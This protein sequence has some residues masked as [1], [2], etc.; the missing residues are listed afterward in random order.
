MKKLIHLLKSVIWI[1][2][3]FI[4]MNF[5][6]AQSKS[7]LTG[8]QMYK[9]AK[10]QELTDKKNQKHSSV[11]N[12][13]K[14]ME[15]EFQ[16]TRDPKTN[17]IPKNILEKEIAFSNKIE[18]GNHSKKSLTKSSKSANS[19]DYH[20]WKNRGPHNVGGRTRA[21]ALDMTNENV[22]FAGGVSGG[23]WRS[24]N[25]G[26]SWRKVTNK[27]QTPS[28][29]S[30][31]QDPR[32][33]YQHIWYY[34]TGEAYGTA[35]EDGAFY[36]G[37]GIFKS[38]NGGRNWR[39]LSST[40]DN[41]VSQTSSFDIINSMVIHPLNGYL[42]VGAYDGVYRSKDQGRSFELVLPGGANNQIEIAISPSGQLYASIDDD[43]VP[44]KGF[45]TSATGDP[46]SWKNITPAFLLEAD[47]FSRTV[48]AVDPSNENKVYF[49]SYKRFDINNEYLLRYNANASTPEEAWTDL[50]ANLPIAIGGRVGNLNLQ[51]SYN[52]MIKVS[53]VDSNLI[54]IGGTNLYRSTTGFTTPAG[55]ESWI[56]GYSL[57]NDATVYPDHHP[58]L[59]NLVFYPSNPNK[60][61]SASDGGVALTEDITTT[62]SDK[63]PVNWISLNNGYLTTQPWHV[64]FDPSGNSDDLLAGFQDNGTWYTSS[65]IPTDPWIS[66]FSG[67]GTYSAIADNGKVRYVSAQ[68]GVIF[69]TNIDKN[70]ELESYAR[71]DP[72]V[73]GIFVTPYILDH[74]NDNIMYFCSR[75]TIWRNNNLDKIPTGSVSSPTTNWVELTNSAVPDG[76]ISALDVSTYPIAN[77][78]Y[79]GTNRG[80][81]FRMDNAIADNQNIV[82]ISTGKGFPE[83]AFVNDINIDPSNH[84]RVIVTFSNYNINSLFLTENGGETWTNISGNLEENADGSGNG[85]SVRSTAFFGGSQGF[86]GSVYQ[87]V[88]AATSTGLFYAYGLRGENTRW[89]KEQFAIGNAVTDEVITRKDG[90]IAL[91][92]HGNGLFSAKFPVYNEVPEPMLRVAYQLDDITIGAYDSKALRKIN[93]KDLF[94]HAKNK[95][96][97]I[98]VTNTNTELVTASIEKDSLLIAINDKEGFGQATIN[99]IA[100][101]GKEQVAEALT[102]NV[103]D[104]L[105]PENKEFIGFGITSINNTRTKISQENADD[106]IIPEGETWNIKRIF[107]RGF[108]FSPQTKTTTSVIIYANNDGKPGEEIY[109]SG[110]LDKESSNTVDTR[111]VVLPETLTLASGTYW[112]SVYD[113]TDTTNNISSLF[114]NWYW[115]LGKNNF[116]YESHTRG[117]DF[118]NDETQITDWISHKDSSDGVIQDPTDLLFEIYGT[119]DG[120]EKEKI[121]LLKSTINEIQVFPNPSAN[122]FTFSFK[123]IS[124]NEKFSILIYDIHGKQVFSKA[125]S[126]NKDLE[127]TW[128]ASQMTPGVYLVNVLDS[129]GR[130]SFKVL[131]Q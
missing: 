62:L 28:I 54:F 102:L 97:G 115:R 68:R 95:K 74:N 51:E 42:Y 5:G 55:K 127:I 10:A 59:H 6:T 120:V 107:A 113:N 79:Y 99:L 60:A 117:I 30:I 31:V 4:G 52:M 56:G 64:S 85:P 49:F 66:Q 24:S 89:Y 98:K 82:D 92:A 96:I 125:G 124:S 122:L 126:Y 71:V 35:G 110:P 73:G 11:E 61:L 45:F 7:T 58:D 19:Y 33:G 37:G 108:I 43:G 8:H 121:T 50:S 86:F 91:A 114:D 88:Y 3:L 80:A 29:T 57:E 94:I 9:F 21:L 20:Y 17:E 16:R 75:G 70:G 72:P 46:D 109:N 44:N 130:Q 15:Y 90:F 38:S 14:R 111:L 123:N 93:I 78:L 65:T 69:R 81:I 84:D 41:D 34:G 2:G 26:A 112:V 53:P 103:N 67:D 18:I 48:M 119:I 101:S 131:K 87:K 76:V 128:D 13:Q 100:T 116:G 27:R 22:I 105:V 47:N 83:G 104:I 77:K 39:Q 1:A 40:N 118:I 106:F 129:R 32:P 63:Q 25:S 36:S 12:A 23:L